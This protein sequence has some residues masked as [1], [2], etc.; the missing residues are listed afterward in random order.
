MRYKKNVI[1]YTRDKIPMHFLLTPEQRESMYKKQIK[2]SIRSEKNQV[3]DDDKQS[4]IRLIEDIIR[5]REDH[6]EKTLPIKRQSQSD[7]FLERPEA[8][9]LE[10][11][12]SDAGIPEL[13]QWLEQIREYPIKLNTPPFTF[14]GDIND[15]LFPKLPSVISNPYPSGSDEFDDSINNHETDPSSNTK[16]PPKKKSISF[17]RPTRDMSQNSH[18]ALVRTDSVEVTRVVQQDNETRFKNYKPIHVEKKMITRKSKPKPM[19]SKE[20]KNEWKAK[21]IEQLNR[22]DDEFDK[23]CQNFQSSSVVRSKGDILANKEAVFTPC[24]FSTTNVQLRKLLKTRPAT[25]DPLKFLWNGVLDPVTRKSRRNDP[26]FFFSLEPES[27]TY[28]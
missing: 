17:R 1:R 14:S 9:I 19:Y 2:K 22:N 21:F 6:C 23:F 28:Q 8:E 24:P 25:N 11:M 7:R 10:A 4:L 5:E 20:Q 13:K 12:R 26:S 27:Q 15:A 18:H 16:I 3:P